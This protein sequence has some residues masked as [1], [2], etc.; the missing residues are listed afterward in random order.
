MRHLHRNSAPRSARAGRGFSMAELLVAI[1]IVAVLTAIAVPSFQTL[2]LGMRLTSY[3]NELVATSMLA[4]SKAISQ[5]ASVTMCQSSDGATC[6]GA[7]T[8]ETGYLLVCSS[9]DGLVCTNSPTSGASTI[10]LSS[11][12]KA[13]TGWKISASDSS[14]RIV[15]QPT[16]TGA[17]TATLTVCRLTPL[18]N[19]E[20]VVR[21]S[22]TGRASVTK[23]NT[24]ACS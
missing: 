13:A 21:I 7:S 20:R 6:G 11:Q 4:R 10:V 24:G 19:A 3:A 16:G 5:N 15:F 12:A 22:P 18:G 23:T 14:G 8:W 17:T 9:N 2:M 1:S